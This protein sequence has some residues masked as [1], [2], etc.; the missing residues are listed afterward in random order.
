MTGS[1]SKFDG[2]PPITGVYINCI[3][4]FLA[5]I[6]NQSKLKLHQNQLLSPA[7]FILNHCRFSHI[8]FLEKYADSA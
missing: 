8:K 2:G 3:K 4:G 5:I 1:A 7:A 6:F